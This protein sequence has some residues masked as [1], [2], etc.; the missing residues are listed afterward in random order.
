MFGN[1]AAERLNKPWGGF[2]ND[3]MILEKRRSAVCRWLRF[4]L[5]PSSN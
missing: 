1:N 5:L 2:L 4:C 3:K